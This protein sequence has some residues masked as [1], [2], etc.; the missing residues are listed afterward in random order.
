MRKR[1]CTT[2]ALTLAFFSPIPLLAAPKNLKAGISSQK[3]QNRIADKHKLI[4]LKNRAELELIIKKGRLVEIVD[5]DAY[6]IS[7]YT[8]MLDPDHQ[9][10][11]WHARPWVLLFLDDV[12][13]EGFD[14][15]KEDFKVTSLVR[16]RWYQK[17]LRR[18]NRNA[19]GGTAWWQQ[20]SHLTG[21]TVDISYRGM[22]YKLQRWFEGKLSLMEKQGLIEA[23]KEFGSRHYHIMVHPRYARMVK[24]LKAKKQKHRKSKTRR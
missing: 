14:T 2:L 22:S 15:F 3:R 6:F 10:L 1:V 11:Y 12:L 9:E 5:T 16:T 18:V 19:I 17:K 21:S 7:E 4:R 23:S 20:S 8:G 24:R 13:R